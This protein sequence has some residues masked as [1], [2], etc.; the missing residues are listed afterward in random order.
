MANALSRRTLLK[1]AA[2]A[3]AAT[4]MPARVLAQAG[5]EPYVNLSATEAAT[6]EAVV[7]RLIPSDLNGPGALEAGAARYIDNALGGALAASRPVYSAGLAALDARARDAHGDAFAT[8]RPEFQDALLEAI[9]HDVEPLASDITD[10][11]VTP[12][13]FF[14]LVLEHTIEGTFSD[15]FYGGNRDFIGWTL[16]GYPGIRLAV[17]E[18][19]QTLDAKPEPT[20]ISAY[21]LPMFDDAEDGV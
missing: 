4:A 8:L 17:T 5:G 20:G 10:Y 15:P 12:G 19:D 6:L 21:D 7:A 11:P 3:G 2:A 9:E 18:S 14:E 1:R 13:A 16:I